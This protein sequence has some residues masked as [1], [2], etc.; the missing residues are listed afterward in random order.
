MPIG[1]VIDPTKVDGKKFHN[2]IA[3]LLGHTTLAKTQWLSNIYT[4]TWLAAVQQNPEN[5]KTDAIPHSSIQEAFP[6]T[7][8]PI[9]LSFRLHLEW[10]LT[11]QIL[12][13]QAFS[14][15]TGTNKRSSKAILS[16]Y[17]DALLAA[18]NDSLAEDS[19][20]NVWG[21]FSSVFGHPFLSR[22]RPLPQDLSSAVCPQLALVATAPN[23]ILPLY[24]RGLHSY[25]LGPLGTGG[26]VTCPPLTLS[27]PAPLGKGDADGFGEDNN[28]DQDAG[29]DTNPGIVHPGTLPNP[30]LK[31]KSSDNTAPAPKR[32]RI[33]DILGNRLG[34]S[35][36]GSE[37]QKDD[38]SDVR[39]LQIPDKVFDPRDHLITV[40]TSAAVTNPWCVPVY[41]PNRTALPPN[42]K[43]TSACLL[44][45]I[46]QSQ[47]HTAIT[48]SSSH[49]AADSHNSF[50]F[51]I[52]LMHTA[53]PIK[54]IVSRIA[55]WGAYRCSTDSDPP[56]LTL[57][58]PTM[59][60]DKDSHF[61]PGRLNPYLVSLFRAAHQKTNA[62]KSTIDLGNWF[63]EQCANSAHTTS[64]PDL[65]C[66]IA[67]TFFTNNIL[68]A[69]Q[70]FQFK[71]GLYITSREEPSFIITPW[72]FIR[73]LHDFQHRT[74]N[75][76]P[77]GGLTATQIH[78]LI[79][80]IYCLFNY[81][82]NDYR[83]SSLLTFGHSPFS[84]FSPLAGHLLLLADRFRQRHMVAAWNDLTT[85]KRQTCTEY[86]FLAISQLFQLYESW[87]LPKF[88]ASHTFLPVQ[89]GINSHL[90]CLSAVIDIQGA[91]K[92]PALTQWRSDIKFF[93][94]N[95]IQYAAPRDSFFSAITPPCFR[96]AM[97]TSYQSSHHANV[98]DTQSV[99]VSA[100][101]TNTRNTV[102]SNRSQDSRSYNR[103]QDTRSQGS[104]PHSRDPRTQGE[105]TRHTAKA[106][107][108]LLVGMGP[109]PDTVRPFRPLL[110]EIN[111][112]RRPNNHLRTPM[113]H[114][115][116]VDDRAKPICFRFCS[117]NGPGCPTR[118]PC[119]FHH[120]DLA[121][122]QWFRNN[123]PK[124]FCYEL[125]NF[126]NDPA[127]K[128]HY[129]ATQEFLSFLRSL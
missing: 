82:F 30:L 19:L 88:E 67:P 96:P 49:A 119:Y 111:R 106:R 126:L 104:S 117:A 38:S 33:D 39:I 46:K 103:S 51:S 62:N 89:V 53:T 125:R 63:K 45:A 47:P 14:L 94:A 66:H 120:L 115:P 31:Y 22:L 24:I 12:W 42:G 65:E 84:R 17:A 99:A 3:Y 54:D 127:M 77:T 112:Q 28:K 121:D 113:C 102:V 128:P 78:D 50:E 73:S 59:R 35:L 43:Q 93:T 76:I 110:D 60:V 21:R 40:A 25:T 87:L 56:I 58:P 5:F 86:V 71:S 32:P 79:M 108:P 6:S 90:I 29:R 81:L 52:E 92:L 68:Q 124:Q 91:I 7:A 107:V 61:A 85:D 36:R 41:L 2:L 118:I 97:A 129:T 109:D 15:A 83:V 100:I 16:T 74:T 37:T 101:T 26:T 9:T 4:E 48:A 34:I 13:D 8:P 55:F 10:S 105:P 80:N 64:C 72:H 11:A 122:Q 123:V 98:S 69:I 75:Q 23:D 1:L 116:G 27:D 114:L 95:Q 57:T 44:T 20:C 70:S 18:N